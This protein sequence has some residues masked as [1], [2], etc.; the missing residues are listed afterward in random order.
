MRTII[1]LTDE[2]LQDLQRICSEEQISRAEAVRRAVGLLVAE[3]RKRDIAS[4]LDR[5]ATAWQSEHAGESTD[6]YLEKIRKEWEH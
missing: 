4:R 3:R 1:D 5:A 2:Q 6:E